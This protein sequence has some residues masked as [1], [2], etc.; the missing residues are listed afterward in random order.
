MTTG[1]LFSAGFDGAVRRWEVV[2]ATAAATAPL[3]AAA[4]PRVGAG[5]GG[6]AEG[7]GGAAA[8]PRPAVAR[9]GLRLVAEVRGTVMTAYDAAIVTFPSSRGTGCALSPK[10]DGGVR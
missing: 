10:S 2:E 9:L 4:A 1:A 6:G 7:G 5:A 3:V 8:A